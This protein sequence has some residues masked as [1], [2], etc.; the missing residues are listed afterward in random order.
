MSW[1][2]L[3]WNSDFRECTA[4]CFEVPKRVVL[5]VLLNF[6]MYPEAQSGTFWI[7]IYLSV[8]CWNGLSRRLLLPA[9]R[10]IVAKVRSQSAYL[11][12]LLGLKHV[13]ERTR[14]MWNAIVAFCDFGRD[15][16]LWRRHLVVALEAS[17]HVPHLKKARA[18]QA[19]RLMHRLSPEIR[20]AN[21]DH[22]IVYKTTHGL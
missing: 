20:A 12:R 17:R 7:F 19:P 3:D 11:L 14:L 18:S 8:Y 22:S 21:L 16:H 15:F 9:Y 5:S 10:Q 6:E 2:G 1:T 4:N 13:F